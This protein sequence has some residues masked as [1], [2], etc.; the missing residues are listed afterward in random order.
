MEEESI[1][2]PF[3]RAWE[4]G[5]P[6]IVSVSDFFAFVNTGHTK[7]Q[8]A[9]IFA[10]FGFYFIHVKRR[11]R[12][13]IVTATVQIMCI[14][15]KTVSLITRF[16]NTGKTMHSHIHQA[17]LG[18]VLHLF[19]SVEGHGVVGDHARIYSTGCEFPELEN[20]TEPAEINKWLS[21]C[22]V[23]ARRKDGQPYPPK[24]LYMLCVGL[25]RYFRECG[26]HENFLDEKD[27]I[28]VL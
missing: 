3:F 12:H 1:I 8:S 26:I 19:L 9:C 5:N 27:S 23:E 22:V 16:D 21:K 10:G 15:I 18:I 2:D 24:S 17:E 11:I 4:I 7:W 6:K 13:Y 14:M 25:L 28:E 20:L